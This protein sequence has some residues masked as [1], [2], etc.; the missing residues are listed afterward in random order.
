[1]AEAGDEGGGGVADAGGVVVAAGGGEG[2]VFAL[3]DQGVGQDAA[4]ALL[5]AAQDRRVG[6]FTSL[7]G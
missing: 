2:A 3:G 5:V 6:R 4:E 1:V 7:R